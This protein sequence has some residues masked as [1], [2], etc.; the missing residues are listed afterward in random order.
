M[1]EKLTDQELARRVKLEKLIELG[2][3]PFGQAFEQKD[4]SA[5][6]RNKVNELTHEQ[7]EEMH[8]E[9]KV[10]GRIMFMRKMG[11]ASFF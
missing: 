4:H 8:L 3:D 7:V 1:E 2:V 9:V 6:I 5:E 11:K 10:A